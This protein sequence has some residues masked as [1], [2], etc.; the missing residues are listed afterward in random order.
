VQVT[1]A[2]DGV[3]DVRVSGAGGPVIEFADRLV[4]FEAYGG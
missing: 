2:G 3:W 1:K 4:M